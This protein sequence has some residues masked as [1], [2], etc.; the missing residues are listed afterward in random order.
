MLRIGEFSVLSQ[1]SIHMLRHYN[2]IGLLIPEYIDDFTGY[3]YYSEKQL[4]I[5]N[6]IKAL[7]SM[8][9][10]LS[11]IKEILTKYTD[12]NDLKKCLE[13]HAVEQREKIENMQQ[14]LNLIE[15]TIENLEHSASVPLY[16]VVLKKFPAH[17]VISLRGIIASP[18]KESV[19]WEK[20]ADER[21][22]QKIQFTNPPWNIARFHDEGF[23][24]ENLDVE[25]QQTVIGEY[26]D[27]EVMKFKR[28]EEITAATLTFKGKYADLMKSLLSLVKDYPALRIY[29]VRSGL[30]F[31]SFLAMWSCLAFKMGQA[32]FFA[33][34]DVVGML[35]L[36]G[37]AGAMSASLVGK[38][39]RKVGV[40]AF[41][42]WGCGLILLA[43]L[44]LYFGGNFYTSIIAG[45]IIIDIGMQCIQLSNQSSIFELCPA[46]SNRVNTIFMTTYFVGGSLG[47]FLSG[48]AWQLFGWA[49]TAGVGVFLCC[50]SLLVT[51]LSAKKI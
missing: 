37:V 32:P 15:T 12:N 28:I 41:N 30:A 2:E 36:C 23:V 10:S 31:G 42:F 48:T 50:A 45:I 39:V 40:R 25:I 17:N 46:A 43:W 19:L 16:S 51:L 35:G 21:K 24:E 3:R 6:K 5:A 7:K 14:Q 38:Y 4:P 47:T 20:L 49:G 9:L 26:S 11:L 13:L 18:D 1:I 33:N 22:L 8:G 34:S 44:L 27:T 29:A